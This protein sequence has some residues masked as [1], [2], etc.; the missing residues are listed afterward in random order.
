MK[1]V[2]IPPGSAMRTRIPK[3]ASSPARDSLKPSKANLEAEG[4]VGCEDR[5]DGRSQV[6]GRDVKGS[7]MP[8]RDSISLT[9]DGVARGLARGGYDFVAGPQ[10]GAAEGEAQA[11][12]A[13][14]GEEEHGASSGVVNQFG[15]F[16]CWIIK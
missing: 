13:T 11:G 3:S 16:G 15:G 14:C 5:S 1:S 12:G 8:A 4:A 9:A 7:Q 10:D 2:R 6:R